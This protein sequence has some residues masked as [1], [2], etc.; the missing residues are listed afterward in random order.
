MRRRI[1]QSEILVII[2]IIV[3]S[4]GCKWLVR[5]KRLVELQ[6]LHFKCTAVCAM[7][8]LLSAC[9]VYT[10]IYLSEVVGEVVMYILIEA[11]AVFWV[12][13]E[14]LLKSSYTDVL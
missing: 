13:F 2:Q 9:T 5:T 6:I 12:E 7:V 14:D 3:S 10:V 1:S 11:A 4:E 8:T